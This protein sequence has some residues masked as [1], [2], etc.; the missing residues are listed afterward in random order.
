MTDP[1]AA[2]VARA[3]AHDIALHSLEVSV[4][5]EL[6]Q[7]AGAAPLGPLTPHR[8][9]SVAKS[10]TG[11]IVLAL[12]HEGRLGLDDRIVDHFPEKRPV[13]PLTA[14]A[15][16]A[17]LLAMR[18]P[19]A[20]TTYR[21]EDGDWLD[22]WF[23]TPPT[24]RPGTL[25]TYDTSGSYVLSALVERIAGAPL[26]DVLRD[27][28]FAPT[29][30]DGMRMRRGPDGVGHGGSGLVCRPRDL[31][32]VAE[33]LNAEGGVLPAGVVRAALERRADPAMQT[34]GAPLRAGYG[35]QFW[36]PPGGGWMMF[37]LGGQIV[38]GDPDRGVAAVVTAN[39]QA[40][41]SGDQRL[42][43][44]FLE[45]IADDP[46]GEDP[47]ELRWPAPRHDPRHARAADGELIAVSG[48]G[49]P[50]RIQARLG[51]DAVEL[52]FGSA[53]SVGPLDRADPVEIPGLGTAAIAARPGH[54]DPVEIPG[55]GVGVATGGWCEPDTLDL[56]VDLSG[57]DIA[58]LRMRILVTDDGL[59]TVQSQGFGPAIGGTWNWFG[60]YAPIAHTGAIR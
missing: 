47:V 24:H 45:A 41:Q 39:A 33:A 30:G 51:A 22:S 53:V 43:S 7:S 57:D 2:F 27:R 56:R 35:A 29:G 36:L 32:R 52:R 54:A 23:R 25:F 46:S 11:L 58:R 38:Y 13:D 12:A 37:G 21:E 15:T 40:C 42:A 19:H 59:I 48:R 55:L 18:G 28:I 31:L 5:G 10:L 20:A 50:P 4:H 14:R 26:E 60:S 1:L 3:A 6:V 34:W 44:L 8:M 49:H 9:Y 16:V 17:D